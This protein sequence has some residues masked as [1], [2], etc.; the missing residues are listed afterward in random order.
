MFLPSA[1]NRYGDN[2]FEHIVEGNNVYGRTMYPVVKPPGAGSNYYGRP[3]GVPD[4]PLMLQF[5]CNPTEGVII[6][7]PPGQPY[8]HLNGKR[9]V[10]LRP[11]ASSF[12]MAQQQEQPTSSKKVPTACSESELEV[13]Q[14]LATLLPFCA[15]EQ[16]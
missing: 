1:A 13:A 6:S 16:Q 2:T 3:Y 7:V 8:A 4:E 15:I 10:W 14:T 5:R 12:L 9:W 11:S